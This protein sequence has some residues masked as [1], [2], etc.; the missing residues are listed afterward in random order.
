MPKLDLDEFPIVIMAH[1]YSCTIAGMTADKYA[2]TFRD[3]GF[4]VMLY[5]HRNFGI[6]DG[7]P[8]HQ[9]NRWTQARG[10][11]DAIDLAC[12]MPNIDATRIALWGDSMSGDEVLVVA[13]LD[14]RVKAV[15][16]QVPACG[17][18]MPQKDSDGTLFRS[19]KDT[20]D[21]GNIEGTPNTTKGPMPVVSLDQETTPSLLPPKSAYHWFMEYG[22]RESSQWINLASHVKPDVPA[23]FTS[24]FCTPY[25]DAAILMMVAHDDEMPGANPSVARHAFE[26]ATEPK[27]LI[28]IDGGHFGIVH[29]PSPLFDLASQ[30]QI[31]FLEEHLI[32]PTSSIHGALLSLP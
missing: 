21:N 11:R 17:K 18:E 1:G 30:E 19:L 31:A 6:S 20:F 16:A 24:V 22:G 29:H 27:K 9:I 5:D 10:Y 7:E 25:I 2:E 26:L 4:A 12:S 28:E 32:G 14:K 8:R 15:V 23:P 3:A 13:A